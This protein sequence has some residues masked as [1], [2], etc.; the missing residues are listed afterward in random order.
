[1]EV[2]EGGAEAAQ[3]ARGAAARRRERRRALVAPH[4]ES[5]DWL[6][7]QGLALV[8]DGLDQAEVRPPSP[9]PRPRSVAATGSRRAVARP[10]A[11][12]SFPA[13]TRS[14]GG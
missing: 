12:W 8:V 11:C 7:A 6:L 13:G 3:A 9:R 2:E 10:G 5:F 14:R 4:V 1:M